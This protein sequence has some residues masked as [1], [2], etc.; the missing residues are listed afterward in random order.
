MLVVISGTHASGKTT[1]IADFV[2]RHPEF[3]MLPDPFEM[4]D[5]A[6]IDLSNDIFFD[7]LQVASARL[8]GLAHSRSWIAE[9]GPLDFLAY[10]DAL[11][12]LRRPTRSPDLF[13]RGLELAAEGMAH[14]DLL[15]LLPLTEADVIEVPDDEDPELREATNDSLLELADDPDLLGNAA[16]IEITGSASSRLAQLES[17]IEG[18]A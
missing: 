18:L 12:T 5:E 2:A 9:R 13:A 8:Q 14:V 7:Q 10:L 16:V 17:A 4:L 11:V 1:L 6:E 3:E 15:V